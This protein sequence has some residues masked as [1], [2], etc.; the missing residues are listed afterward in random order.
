MN[1]VI[2]VE[3]KIYPE[4]EE[5]SFYYGKYTTKRYMAKFNDGQILQ[6]EQTV[7]PDA[8]PYDGT[9]RHLSHWT[10]SEWIDEAKKRYLNRQQE[11]QEN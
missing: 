11:K 8:K 6:V 3:V 1:D 4:V 10:N 5:V 2:I 9:G 7:W